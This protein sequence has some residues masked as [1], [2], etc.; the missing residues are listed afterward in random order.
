MIR[1]YLR[2]DC[3]KN[4]RKL[5][6][7]TACS[8]HFSYTPDLHLHEASAS[9]FGRTLHCDISCRPPWWSTSPEDVQPR[10]RVLST[11]VVSERC[12]NPHVQRTSKPNNRIINQPEFLDYQVH[13]QPDHIFV[14]YMGQPCI[15]WC[16]NRH[17]GGCL[18]QSWLVRRSCALPDR[19]PSGW[20]L[21]V[22]TAWL[23]TRSVHSVSQ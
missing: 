2:L 10:P 6:V 20:M 11:A 19:H 5:H 17:L 1:N 8:W 23:S 15:G 13:H 22:S 3:G 21:T 4:D 16:K 9:A 7:A 14:R 18:P 12:L